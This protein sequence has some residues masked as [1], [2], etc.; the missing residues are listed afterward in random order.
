M[1][2]ELLQVRDLKVSFPEKGGLQTVVDGIS[3]DIHRG[4]IVGIVGE[5][6][7]GKSMTALSIMGLLS[8]EAQMG[9]NSQMIF[10][11]EDLVKMDRQQRRKV[12]GVEMSMVFQEPMTSLNP[13]MKIGDQVAVGQLMAELGR[14]FLPADVITAEVPYIEALDQLDEVLSSETPKAQA[15]KDLKDKEAALENAEKYRESLKYPHAV[16]GDVLYWAD[17]VEKSRDLYE[18]ALQTMN[19]AVS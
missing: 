10:N 11:G 14:E 4:E 2:N 6:G 7:S 19:D 5:S 12:Q 15:Y 9:E 16:L 8:S 18:E 17:Q 1:A 13:V 3:F